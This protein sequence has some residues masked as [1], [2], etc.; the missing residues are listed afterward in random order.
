MAWNLM[1]L[2][3]I[4]KSGEIGRWWFKQMQIEPDFSLARPSGADLKTAVSN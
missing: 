3:Q 2:H 1:E 4:E